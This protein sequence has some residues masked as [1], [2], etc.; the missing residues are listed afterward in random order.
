[1]ARLRNI[2]SSRHGALAD[3]CLHRGDNVLNTRLALQLKRPG[4]GNNP[5]NMYIILTT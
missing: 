2:A 3:E 5:H 4:P 1:M